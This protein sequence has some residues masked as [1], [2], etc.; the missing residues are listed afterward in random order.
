MPLQQLQPA[1]GGAPTRLRLPSS[2][3][4]TPRPLASSPPQHI[5][6]A[7]TQDK[8]IQQW[9][10]NTGDMV[11]VYARSQNRPPAGAP[12]PPPTPPPST[13][14][15]PPGESARASPASSQRYRPHACRRLPVECGRSSGWRMRQ[16]C[17]CL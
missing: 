11:Q 10:L 16:S 9:D 13:P 5:V 12:P 6:L 15:P 8:K 7:G 1:L 14:P 3:R 17:L 4:L 2:S